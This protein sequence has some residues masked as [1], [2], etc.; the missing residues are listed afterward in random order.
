MNA[1]VE[2]MLQLVRRV[3]VAWDQYTVQVRLPEDGGWRTQGHP[4]DAYNRGRQVGPAR[5][6]SAAMSAAWNSVEEGLLELSAV[7]ERLREGGSVG[8]IDLVGAGWHDHRMGPY[9]SAP[10]PLTPARA[11]PASESRSAIAA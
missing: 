3:Q 6:D 2:R 7:T 1:D 4:W 5:R 11:R 8:D 10:A 9:T